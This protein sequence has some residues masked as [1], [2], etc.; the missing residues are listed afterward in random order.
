M[1]DTALDQ[2]AGRMR[3]FEACRAR[4]ADRDVDEIPRA[5]AAHSDAFGLENAFRFVH[6]FGDL[7]AQTAGSNV[8]QR[9]H[10][11]AA[12]GGLQSR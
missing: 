11:A 9:V 12:E 4:H 5:G 3:L 7:F 10:G 1:R 2:I 8:E 6:C